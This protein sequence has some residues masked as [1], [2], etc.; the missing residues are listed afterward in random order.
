MQTGYAFMN[1]YGLI[2]WDNCMNNFL[3]TN[4]N[5]IYRSPNLNGWT[6]GLMYSNGIKDDT[7]KWSDNWHYY[8]AG[9]KYAKGAVKSSLI[10]EVE[11]KDKSVDPAVQAK[12]ALNYGIEYNTGSWTPMFT[13]RFCHSRQEP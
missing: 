3:R 11:S 6:I 5:I 2:G 8:G 10:F 13:Y 12:Y 4:N 9:V 1:G 7:N